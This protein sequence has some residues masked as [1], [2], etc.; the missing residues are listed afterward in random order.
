M[1]RPFFLAYYMEGKPRGFLSTFPQ[2][3]QM[4]I[5]AM[6]KKFLSPLKEPYHE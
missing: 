3:K 5:Y 6:I 4:L 2:Y 1:Q